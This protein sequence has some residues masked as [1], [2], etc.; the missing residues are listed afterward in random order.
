M[1]GSN[2]CRDRRLSG[3]SEGGGALFMC[4]VAGPV[5]LFGIGL[6]YS[7]CCLPQNV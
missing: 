7:K 1:T 4:G 3:A 6:R 2:V 5:L